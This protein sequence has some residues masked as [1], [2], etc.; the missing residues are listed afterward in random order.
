MGAFLTVLFSYIEDRV[1]AYRD[2]GKLE[3]QG[4]CLICTVSGG[5]DRLLTRG[6]NDDEHAAKF[7]GEGGAKLMVCKAE[8]S[9]KLDLT[10]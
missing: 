1:K 3:K 8:R 9:L 7:I 6:G 2:N 4:E 10:G 5:R